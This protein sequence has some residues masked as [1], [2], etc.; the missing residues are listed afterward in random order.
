ML[1]QFLREVRSGIC[2][3]DWF[4]NYLSRFC[5]GVDGAQVS[6]Q[7]F[8]CCVFSDRCEALQLNAQGLCHRL[9]VYELQND[10]AR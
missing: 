1:R 7:D 3:L 2:D 6:S 8:A 4:R 10:I 5:D 9:N